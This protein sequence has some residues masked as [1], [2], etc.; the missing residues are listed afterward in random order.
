MTLEFVVAHYLCRHNH[1]PTVLQVGAFD[2]QANDPLLTVFGDRPWRGVLV[3]PQPGPFERL[4]HRYAESAGIQTFNVAISDSEQRKALYSFDPEAPLPDWGHQLA[5]FDRDHLLRAERYLGVRAEP[6]LREDL[7]E[8]WTFDRLFREA[9]VGAVDILQVDTEGYDYEILRLFD[10]PRRLPPIVNYEHEHLSRG[11][12]ARAANSYWIT[13]TGSPW[14]V[15][16]STPSP[17]A[18]REALG[19]G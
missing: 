7:V 15:A 1:E 17:I 5:S 14:G 16:R 9:G 10:V 6:F 8:C 11:D 4:A 2:G 13:G 19:G 3:E 18:S 12:R